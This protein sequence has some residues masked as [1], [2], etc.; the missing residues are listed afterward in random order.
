MSVYKRGKVYW[1]HFWFNGEHI[2]RATKQGNPR[3][4]SLFAV[5]A[6]QAGVAARAG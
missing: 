4:D 1:F 3:V 5:N 6:V 2:Q